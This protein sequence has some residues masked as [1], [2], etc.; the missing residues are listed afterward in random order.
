M[1]RLKQ[2][3]EWVVDPKIRQKY[4][5]GETTPPKPYE[6]PEWLDR[7]VQSASKFFGGDYSSI[8]SIE[9]DIVKNKIEVPTA[10][11]II[12]TNGD[13]YS[14]K[15]GKLVHNHILAY[16]MYKRIVPLNKKQFEEWRK[17]PEV[18]TSASFLMV[19][20]SPKH[21][22]NIYLSESYYVSKRIP[23]M[24][25]LIKLTTTKGN[26]FEKGIKATG[27]RFQPKAVDFDKE[28]K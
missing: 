23:V 20:S 25:M 21:P 2:Y 10:R 1:S 13:F 15:T 8:N 3:L 18:A 14:S 24:D 19:Q 22:R 4:K 16:L 17:N 5:M 26:K 9:E 28:T 12:L 6:I 7:W 27:L 11:T